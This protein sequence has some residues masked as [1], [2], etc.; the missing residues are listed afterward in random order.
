M[1]SGNND[2]SIYTAVLEC[3]ILRPANS[4]HF[5]LLRS[6]KVF[7]HFICIVLP[8]A[9]HKVAIEATSRNLNID[10]F[11]LWIA[12]TSDLIGKECPIPWKLNAE[13]TFNKRVRRRKLW[14][15]WGFPDKRVCRPQ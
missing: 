15:E 1:A 4:G 14:P 13:E 2:L 12:A 10:N 3:T 9:Q 5:R 11:K 6:N 7:Y 8:F